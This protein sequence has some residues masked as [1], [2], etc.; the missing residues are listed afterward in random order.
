MSLQGE[1]TDKWEDMAVPG[2]AGLLL[3]KWVSVDVP[4]ASKQTSLD[5]PKD[6]KHGHSCP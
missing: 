2:A 6:P 1:W 5:S 4:Q 3:L